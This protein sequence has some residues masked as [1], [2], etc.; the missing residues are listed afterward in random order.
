MERSP[1]YV[2]KD[3]HSQKTKQKKT[4][5]GHVSQR[6]KGAQCGRG[7]SEL[8]SRAKKEKKEKEITTMQLHTHP[9]T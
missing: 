1:V 7:S 5:E 3:T 4:G 8:Q 9:R 2:R 6:P